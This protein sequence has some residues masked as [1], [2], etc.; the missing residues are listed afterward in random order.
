MISVCYYVFNRLMRRE[1]LSLFII[2]CYLNLFFDWFDIYFYFKN[3]V[4]DY[5]KWYFVCEEVVWL[6]FDKRVFIC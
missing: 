5:F 4:K 3:L 1:F 2:S 6:I